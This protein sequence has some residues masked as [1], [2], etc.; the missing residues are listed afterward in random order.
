[1][2][3][4]EAAT[5]RHLG[6][7]IA[8]ALVARGRHQGR[9]WLATDWCAGISPRLAF[10]ELRERDD[11]A[12]R[13]RLLSHL[14]AVATAYARLHALGILHG[15]VHPDNLLIGRH[16]EVTL[17]DFGLAEPLPPLHLAGVAARGGV[18]PFLPPEH[19]AALLRQAESPPPTEAGE[20]YALAACSC[21]GD[22]SSYLD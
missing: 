2:L 22:R 21:A 5:L 1:V 14:V 8:P 9:P 13:R 4:R 12:S 15:D 16:G 11:P 10:G 18:A 6:G 19:A 3:A 17:L 20:Q 7:A